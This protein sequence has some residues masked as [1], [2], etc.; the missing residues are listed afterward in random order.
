MP[1]VSFMAQHKTFNGKVYTLFDRVPRT[2][3]EAQGKA[4]TIKKRG[5]R[6]RVIK[7]RAGH[8][9]YFRGEF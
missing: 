6:A 8:Y 1:T 9:V 5:G 4:N 7:G 3:A 2:K